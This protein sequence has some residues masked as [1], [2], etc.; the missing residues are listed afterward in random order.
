LF[1]TYYQVASILN[2]V[3]MASVSLHRIR[4]FYDSDCLYLPGLNHTANAEPPF[5]YLTF[6]GSANPHTANAEPPFF[7]LTFHGSANPHKAMCNAKH[8]KGYR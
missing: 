4:D 5:F 3:L 6:H 1:S 8:G 2:L 7:Y